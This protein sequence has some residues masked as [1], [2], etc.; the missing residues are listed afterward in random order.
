MHTAT[1][2]VSA[3]PSAL[4]NTVGFC[5]DAG[6]LEQLVLTR[7]TAAKAATGLTMASAKG[8]DFYM[9]CPPN[10]TTVSWRIVEINTGA[11]TSGVA[12]LPAATTLQQEY[13]RNAAVAVVTSIQLGINRIY[14]ETDY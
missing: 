7:G 4:N 5:I 3:D 11:E 13:W 14:I 12:T 9:F 1:T 10:S 8:F 6:D 2:V